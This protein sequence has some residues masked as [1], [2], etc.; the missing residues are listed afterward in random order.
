MR[1]NPLTR[2][3]GAAILVLGA[4]GP[5]KALDLSQNPEE[6]GPTYGGSFGNHWPMAAPTTWR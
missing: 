4:I 1:R 2:L 3:A 5:V 6:N